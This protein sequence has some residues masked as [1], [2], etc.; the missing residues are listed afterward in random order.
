M[1]VICRFRNILQNVYHYDKMKEEGHDK[2]IT[3]FLEAHTSADSGNLLKEK[4]YFQKG[5]MRKWQRK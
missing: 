2:K 3:I 5:V 1:K 4:V